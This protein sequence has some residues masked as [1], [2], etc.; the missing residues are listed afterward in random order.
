MLKLIRALLQRWFGNRPVP[1]PLLRGPKKTRAKHD[2]DIGSHYYFHDLLKQLDNY[3]DDIERMKTFSPDMYNYFRKVGAQVLPT[4]QRIIQWG[5]LPSMWGHG[6]RRP[7]QGMW[8]SSN[9]D[10]DKVCHIA[11]AHYMKFKKRAF[12]EAS[13][14]DIYQVNMMYRWKKKHLATGSFHVSVD[15]EGQITLLRECRELAEKLP[16]KNHGTRGYYNKGVWSTATKGGGMIRHVK[17]TYPQWLVDWLP[18]IAKFDEEDDDDRGWRTNDI[19]VLASRIFC[20]VVNGS[21]NAVDGF[22]VMVSKTGRTARFNIDLLRT[23]YFFAERDKTVTV[24]GRTQPIFHIVRAHKR[25]LAG[26]EVKYVKT[27]FRGVRSFTWLGYQVLITMP[28][29]HHR[30]IDEFDAAAIEEAD[31]EEVK[32]KTVTIVKAGEIIAA[33]MRGDTK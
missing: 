10:N 3:F 6:A 1:I 9:T 19:T 12:V 33:A 14:H 24:S 20:V 4:G 2:D 11:F 8:H 5:T 7:S 23:P 31:L 21:A 30:P 13:N 29:L 26:G 22:Q 28:G 25:V 27:H 18:E 16:T 15:P 32:E 17:W